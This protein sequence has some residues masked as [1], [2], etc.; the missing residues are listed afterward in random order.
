MRAANRIRCRTWRGRGSRG[1]SSGRSHSHSTGDFEIW[2]LPAVAQFAQLEE[3]GP[4][5]GL[6]PQV[7]ERLAQLC[8]HSRV[9]QSE[10]GVDLLLEGARNVALTQYIGICLAGG[11]DPEKGRELAQKFGQSCEPPMDEAEID[12]TFNSVLRYHAPNG[13]LGYPEWALN[14]TGNAERLQYLHGGQMLWN[15]DAKSWLIWDGVRWATNRGLE[16]AMLRAR[17]VPKADP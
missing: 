6:L 4:R 13:S 11:M 15:A 1:R 10:E 5:V 16:P 2:D 14:D 7:G 8:D 17:D 9:L 12:A 3:H